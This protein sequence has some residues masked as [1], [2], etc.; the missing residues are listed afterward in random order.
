MRSAPGGRRRRPRISARE[1]FDA[2]LASIEQQAAAVWATAPLAAARGQAE[3]AAREFD[4]G[5]YA[6]AQGE[7]EAATAALA[8]IEAGRSAALADALAAGDDAIRRGNA[9]A[10]AAAFELADA[11]EPG[12]AAAQ[13]GLERAGKLDEVFALLDE[14]SRAEQAGRSD[15]AI[16][17]Y[18]QALALDAQAPGAA[19][20]I[21]RIQAGRAEEAFAAVMS[22]GMA[23]LA[24]GRLEAADAAFGQ[25]RSMRPGDTAVQEALD[26]LARLRQA[27]SL[28]AL[29]DRALRAEQVEDWDSARKAW[30]DALAIEPALEPARAGLERSTPRAQLDAR[31]GALVDEPRKLWSPAGKSEA[32][33][34]LAEAAAAAAPNALLSQR[35]ATLAD[36]LQAARTPVRLTLQSDGQTEVVIYRVGRIGTF[37]RHEL[38]VIPGRYAAVGTRPGY[39]DVRREV[40]VVPGSVPEPV[41]VKCEEPL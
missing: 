27:G 7:W 41:M 38:E 11:I 15:A 5:D 23:A 37:Q 34:A 2:K 18:R 17:A 4:L 26:E 19:E 25:A 31:I 28:Q 13:R 9:E 35:A 30:S 3:A 6:A 22:R 20:A 40:E 39:R 14:A 21:D 16:E 24:D 1:A 32:E 36:L 33:A 12:N 29:T 10:A 8:A